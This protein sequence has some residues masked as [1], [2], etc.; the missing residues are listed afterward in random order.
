M[1]GNFASESQLIARMCNIGAVVEKHRVSAESVPIMGLCR[2]LTPKN[3]ELSRC[4]GF[5]KD[6]LCNKFHR[7]RTS[8]GNVL[9]MTL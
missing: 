6:L 7:Y 4:V 1:V 9:N 8:C 2:S 3:P 5:S